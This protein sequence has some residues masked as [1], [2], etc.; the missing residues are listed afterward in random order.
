MGLGGDAELSGSWRVPGNG[1]GEM[2]IGR[3]SGEGSGRHQPADQ[4]FTPEAWNGEV[5]QDSVGGD[6]DQR[7][8]ADGALGM[9]SVCGETKDGRA[10]DG[11]TRRRERRK[12][13]PGRRLGR[14][15]KRTRA[16]G[17]GVERGPP[18]AERS[19]AAGRPAY[20]AQAHLVDLLRRVALLLGAQFVAQL[21]RHLVHHVVPQ[22]HAVH[23]R[24]RVLVVLGELGQVEAQALAELVEDPEGG[25]GW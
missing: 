18:S 25:R 21:L 19:R 6:G 7:P 10:S 3:V 1:Q 16:H 12:A 14:G 20:P 9:G 23:F 4:R 15:P 17:I 13:S 2:D 22:L 24:P 8:K 5:V 11:E